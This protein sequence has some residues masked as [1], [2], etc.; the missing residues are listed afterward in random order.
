MQHDTAL[1]LRIHHDAIKMIRESAARNH[2]SVAA[3]IRF[4]LERYLADTAVVSKGN[5][6]PTDTDIDWES[7]DSPA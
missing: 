5:I 2:R 4:A 7:L 6:S 3:E 1:T